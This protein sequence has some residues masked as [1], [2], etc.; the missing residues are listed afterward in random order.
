M[1]EYVMKHLCREAGVADRFEIQS[2]AV[3]SEE[4][5]NDIYPP[6]KR[7]LREKGVPFDTRAARRITPADYNY[8]DY[9]LCMDQSNLR[10]LERI[11]GEDRAHKV[12]LLLPEGI[13]DPWY[14][15][16]FE[17]AYCDILSG[18]RILLQQLL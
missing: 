4:I 18:C 16:D 2:A 13:S 11:I 6:A 8:F 17:T 3:S 9:I 12:S 10:W 15:G 7:K 1:A 14:T 5:G